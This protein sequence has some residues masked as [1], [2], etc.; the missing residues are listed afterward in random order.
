LAQDQTG[1]RRVVVL[2]KPP[3]SRLQSRDKGSSRR[4]GFHSV[5]FVETINKRKP[6]LFPKA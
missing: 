3:A 6:A 2:E 5:G 1:K 4:F